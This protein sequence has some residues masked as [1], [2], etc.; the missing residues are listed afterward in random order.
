MA[1]LSG[2]S[3]FLFKP[4]NQLSIRLLLA[5]SGAY[6]F[7]ICV[8][9]L[10][11]ELYQD[12]DHK[13]GLYILLGFLLQIIL[14]Y[15][16]EGIEHGHVHIHKNDDHHHH[17]PVVMM[18]SL[19]LHSFLEG[20][21]L[22]CQYPEVFHLKV[23]P[24]MAGII[25]HNIPIAYTLMSMLLLSGISNKKASFWLFLFAAMAPAGALFSSFLQQQALVADLSSYY[26]IIMA[27][28]IGIF[29][30]IST[31][32][33]FESSQNH[34]FNL[35]KLLVIIAGAGTAVMLDIF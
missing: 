25:L 5:F 6:L 4:K 12:G 22:S 34:R 18:I 33:L 3:I 24:L 2:M 15:F 1:F 32:I 23:N 35:I 10:I 9:H 31:T 7:A 27:L 28:V 16:S 11:P 13:T 19:S 21:P 30:H 17:F 20:M 14:E 8:M 29:L 26:K